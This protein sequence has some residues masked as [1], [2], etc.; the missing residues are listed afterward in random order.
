MKKKPKQIYNLCSNQPS[1]EKEKNAI[2]K[3]LDNEKHIV[4]SINDK[5]TILSN[6]KWNQLELNCTNCKATQISK[7]H[8]YTISHTSEWNQFYLQSRSI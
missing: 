1:K 7:K 3:A 2:K 6:D 5:K 8:G 4:N